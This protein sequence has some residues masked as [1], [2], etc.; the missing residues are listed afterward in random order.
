[1]FNIKIKTKKA[2][3]KTLIFNLLLG[4]T[5][6][7]TSC[8]DEKQENKITTESEVLK[9]A[10]YPYY[11]PFVALN[12][13]NKPIGFD[14]DLVEAIAK[15][16][17][18]KLEIQQKS[19]FGELFSN[20]KNKESDLVISGITKTE[21]RQESFAFSDIYYDTSLSTVSLH[22]QPNSF[23]DGMK[24][25]VLQGTIM[26]DWAKS[27]LN[28]KFNNIQV[29]SFEKEYMS[30]AELNSKNINFSIMEEVIA[31]NFNDVNGGD[32]SIKTLSDTGGGYAVMLE[33][34]NTELLTKV[35]TALTELKNE[36][37]IDQLKT[38]WLP[39]DK[40]EKTQ[41]NAKNNTEKNTDGNEQIGSQDSALAVNDQSKDLPNKTQEEMPYVKHD[42]SSIS[43]N[44]NEVNSSK[45]ESTNI[46]SKVEKSDDS[47]NDLNYIDVKKNSEKTDKS[48]DSK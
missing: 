9:V 32:I 41:S 38:K 42:N 8:N 39:Y 10:V 6:I 14:I 13:G 16:L 17:N 4:L 37:F 48:I 43:S 29:M 15:K 33:K 27:N 18:K 26:E 44:S 3:M 30:L 1:M 46:E 40:K 36:G 34:N 19:V 31:N 21:K 28:S 22:D 23:F 2:L 24:V 5:L 45:V 11:P 47:I 12:N 20:I 35:N 25:G 7:V